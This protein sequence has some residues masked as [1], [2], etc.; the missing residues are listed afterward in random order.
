[1][2]TTPS[3]L[4]T[5][6]YSSLNRT[7]LL[8]ISEKFLPKYPS[9]LQGIRLR[10]IFNKK[11]LLS[12]FLGRQS[13]SPG[14]STLFSPMP[15]NKEKPR[16]SHFQLYILSTGISLFHCELPSFS[17]TE[18]ADQKSITHNSPKTTSHVTPSSFQLKPGKALPFLLWA[19]SEPVQEISALPA[20]TPAGHPPAY[21]LLLLIQPLHNIFFINSTVLAKSHFS[22]LHSACLTTPCGFHVVLHFSDQIFMQLSCAKQYWK[23]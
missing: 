21:S 18:E 9:I 17:S 8:N 10:I 1:M 4:V 12:Y 20:L 16:Y 19:S 13:K 11:V 2:D 6:R 14:L 3:Q 23:F 7:G 5:L 22:W 15:S